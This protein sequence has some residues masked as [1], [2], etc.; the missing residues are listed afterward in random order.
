MTCVAYG[1]QSSYRGLWNH[2]TGDRHV[3]WLQLWHEGAFSFQ[4]SVAVSLFRIVGSGC[5]TVSV[6]LFQVVASIAG[7]IK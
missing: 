2:S 1:C 6:M 7:I 3:S 4:V 5:L